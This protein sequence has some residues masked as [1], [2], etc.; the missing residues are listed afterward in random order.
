MGKKPVLVAGLLAASVA[1]CGCWKN[2]TCD[3][4][5]CGGSP[6]VHSG[7]AWN[8]SPRGA[9]A[10][11]PT[12]TTMTSGSGVNTMGHPSTG[13]TPMGSVPTSGM[14]GTMPQGGMRGMPTSGSPYGNSSLGM[15]SGSRTIMDNSLTPT[16]SSGTP[17]G[18]V[19]INR[20]LPPTDSFSPT[21]TGTAPT[22]PIHSI[23]GS[24][25]APVMDGASNTQ[26]KYP[27]AGAPIYPATPA[28]GGVAPVQGSGPVIPDQ[29]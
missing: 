24:P 7:H 5:S 26:S 23:Q 12:G 25:T 27:G 29:E 17:A 19:Q 16:R 28:V 14:S 10:G 1:L 22:A 4:G 6:P 9:V 18:G 3:S 11:T 13:L 15:P 21:G 8:T 2:R 20:V